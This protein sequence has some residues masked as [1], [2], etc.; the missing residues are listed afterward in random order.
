MP[1]SYRNIINTGQLSSALANGDFSLSGVLKKPSVTAKYIKGYA[2]EDAI[3]ALAKLVG[4]DSAL[5]KQIFGIEDKQLD[6]YDPYHTS[7]AK[8]ED[9]WSK[10]SPYFFDGKE[11]QANYD[12]DTNTFKRNLY[13]EFGF[14]Q[15]DFWYEDPF[16][17]SFELFFDEN[18]PLFDNTN[19]ANSLYNFIQK[20][21]QIDP[22]GYGD[23]ERLWWE[24]RNIFFKIFE[25]DLH[26]NSNRNIKNKAYYITK[27]AGLQ[28][29]NKKMIKYGPPDGDKIT[30]TLN[31]D[32]AMIAWYL[33]ELYKNIIYSY[34]N[35][36][37]T[38]PENVI[39]FDM[40]IKINDMRIFQI[41]QSNNQ[42]SQNVP[43]DTNY[44]LNQEITYALSPKS[45]IVYTLYDCT[46]DFFQSKNYGDELEIGGY[47]ASQSYTPQTLS[48]DIYYKSVSHYSEFP[49]IDNNI[50]ITPWG[51]T[52]YDDTGQIG[53][54]G[55]KQNLYDN[56]DR[57]QQNPANT[58]PQSFLNSLLGKAAQT[59]VNTAAS[60]ADSLETKLR[61][62][63][64]SAVNSL[65]SQ[66]NKITGIN[67]IEPDNVYSANFN[68]RTS[69]S[70]LGS[71]L[72]SG[73]LTDLQDVLRN[74]ANF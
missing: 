6:A 64:G 17:P 36:R 69:L 3:Q 15:N 49:L 18:S 42:S 28:N 8:A 10:S 51:D 57:I 29:L 27:I 16:I 19:S 48:F 65:L 33:A 71:S 5:F 4:L 13:S 9:F 30:V 25:T 44:L 24:F 35:Q 63:R 34:K 40:T 54:D 32:V 46:F 74:S 52:L 47:G 73:L 11:I 7:D 21:L 55:T 26:R 45:E 50:S 31:E 39:R 68:N 67:K 41:P 62:I 20:Y 37:Y 22:A 12:E 38:M 23:R 72:A 70:N 58:A 53:A 61:T 59:V 66:M 60:Y 14:R 1:L 2:K 43:V 56:L